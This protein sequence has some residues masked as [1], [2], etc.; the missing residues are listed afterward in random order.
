MTPSS[1]VMV[2]GIINGPVADDL[3][4]VDD[5][6]FLTKSLYDALENAFYIF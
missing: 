5:E 4:G 2:S 6:K 3:T 1:F